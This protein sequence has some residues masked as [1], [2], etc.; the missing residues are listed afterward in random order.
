M[1]TKE[2]NLSVVYELLFNITQATQIKV[3]FGHK[4]NLS[5]KYFRDAL[6]DS[7][8]YV[9]SKMSGECAETKFTTLVKHMKQFG[10]FQIE[11]VAYKMRKNTN[12]ELFIKYDWG[13]EKYDTNIK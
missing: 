11:K 10:F 12:N 6:E 2:L 13:M 1:E 5:Q 4:E 7:T 3:Y 9:E 8:L